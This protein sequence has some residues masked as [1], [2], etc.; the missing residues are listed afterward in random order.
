MVG[1]RQWPRRF[2]PLRIFEKTHHSPY[3]WFIEREHVSTYQEIREAL[4]R[5]FRITHEWRWPVRGLP[6]AVNLVVGLTMVPRQV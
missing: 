3:K 2:A 4:R 6:I 5:R 1:P